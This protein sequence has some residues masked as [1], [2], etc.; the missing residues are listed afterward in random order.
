MKDDKLKK[1]STV[2]IESTQS[3]SK[4][5]I[6]EAKIDLPSI[7]NINNLLSAAEKNKGIIDISSKKSFDYQ[8]M[9]SLHLFSD[10]T[11]I[12]DLIK[13]KNY[14]II[15]Y[16]LG[17]KNFLIMD[18]EAKEDSSRY[19][20]VPPLSRE[21]Y[22]GMAYLPESDFLLATI[23]GDKIMR[24]WNIQAHT[25]HCE[26]K[27]NDLNSSLLQSTKRPIL[28]LNGRV[29]LLGSDASIQAWNI[30][31]K[32]CL[33]TLSDSGAAVSTLI[34][35]DDF[36][37]ISGSEDG[38]IKIW[39]IPQR[40]CSKVLKGH[41]S[42]ITCFAI[43][44][45]GK[46][47]SGSY[48]TVIR[49]W[50]SLTG[51]CLFK[52]EGHTG[53]ITGLVL[54][55]DGQLVSCSADA[56]IKIWDLSQN[57]C[58]K[59][60][61]DHRDRINAVAVDERNNLYSVSG[62]LNA[63]FS[64]GDTSFRIWNIPIKS[65][66]I[67]EVQG[68]LKQIEKNPLVTHL[69]L[70]NCVLGNESIL[71]LLRILQ[72]HPSMVSVSLKNCQIT[73][74]GIKI[75]LFGLKN[76]KSI[77]EINISNNNFNIISL[78]FMV[79]R[80]KKN[81]F[82]LNVIFQE[83]SG[84]P[85]H[86]LSSRE[87]KSSTDDFDEKFALKLQKEEFEKFYTL[88][89]DIKNQRYS[90]FT[91]SQEAPVLH[92]VLPDGQAIDFDEFESKGD[93]ACGFY[94]LGIKREECVEILLPLSEDKEVRRQLAKE[95][96][97]ELLAN[98]LGKAATS[99]AKN[100]LDRYMD[101]LDKQPALEKEINTEIKKIQKE[102]QTMGLVNLI[103]YMEENLTIYPTLKPSLIRLKKF[104]E[105]FNQLEVETEDYCAS[106]EMYVSYITHSLGKTGW[107][108]YQSALL[109]AREKNFD[110]HIWKKAE[111]ASTTLSYID[112][113]HCDKPLTT[114]HILHTNRFTHFNLLAET[115]RKFTESKEKKYDKNKDEKICPEDDKLEVKIS[116]KLERK[117]EDT[118]V[119][120]NLDLS[121]LLKNTSPVVDVST[122]FLF[123]YYNSDILT[124]KWTVFSL[125]LIPPDRIAVGPVGDDIQIWNIRN[126]KL[127]KTISTGSYG[128][129]PAWALAYF[130]ENRLVSLDRVRNARNIYI[131][132]INTGSLVKKITANHE[133]AIFSMLTWSSHHL[134]TAGQEG[135]VR[136][137]D[138]QK[139][140]LI[141]SLNRE[142]IIYCMAILSYRSFASG[143]SDGFIRIYNINDEFKMSLSRSFKAHEAKIYAIAGLKGYKLASASKDHTVKIWDI[144]G[145]T[146]L[147]TL[148]GHSRAVYSL[149]VL[150]NDKLASAGTDR[151][152]II[153]DTQ[154]GK[155][156]ATLKGHQNR[157]NALVAFNDG[158]IVSGSGSTF[159]PD[160]PSVRV[161]KQNPRPITNYDLTKLFR[162]LSKNKTK[163][164]LILDGLKL[165]H[166]ILLTL[167]ELVNQNLSLNF[168][169]LRNCGI[170]DTGAKGLFEST[171]MRKR[172]I[173]ISDNPIS[174][175]TMT[176]FM[177][178]N[179]FE[180]FGG[181][182]TE[183]LILDPSLP[184]VTRS[185]LHRVQVKV[186]EWKYFKWKEEDRWVGHVA[187]KTFG[188][189]GVYASFWPGNCAD[190]GFCEQKVSH[191]HSEQEDDRFFSNLG[192]KL[193]TKKDLYT[194]DVNTINNAFNT[195]KS[196]GWEWA[197]RGSGFLK[198]HKHRNCSGLAFHLLMHG[199]IGKL[200]A[201][202]P[203][204]K[205]GEKVGEAVRIAV[206]AAQVAI[207]AA[208]IGLTLTDPQS[209][210]ASNFLNVSRS[211]HTVHDLD[212]LAKDIC[213]LIGYGIDGLDNIIITPSD[214]SSIAKIAEEN[215]RKEHKHFRDYAS[216]EEEIDTW[217]KQPKENNFLL[218]CNKRI[219]F[220][221]FRFFDD[222]ERARMS[223]VCQ[224]YY[225]Y[226]S[227]YQS[228]M[229]LSFVS[230]SN[231]QLPSE[232]AGSTSSA[233]LSSIF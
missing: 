211:L 107:L 32:K 225:N 214:I 233:T 62:K 232:S 199:D 7:M 44:P 38:V 192:Q 65:P 91:F 70:D 33:Y 54:L 13:V 60:L 219:K 88:V 185:D 207:F 84:S 142:A 127:L 43:L 139:E 9:H 222:R 21:L 111:R 90:G 100:L 58:I 164:Q 169:S 77:Q 104:T 208:E 98:S 135:I 3:E 27:V 25:L 189:D 182:P 93:G 136:L 11:T 173:A 108:G 145:A 36:N 51:E 175:E 95:I 134:I 71:N 172:V 138:L 123:D 156:I 227:I 110:L 109:L 129:S 48:D 230:S 66:G 166:K 229:Q 86:R 144:Y 37:I 120:L 224:Y 130:P 75:L 141:S 10:S 23:T 101:L 102:F 132:N 116:D 128:G 158:T 19:S 148:I 223:L 154:K 103:K 177:K 72:P 87:L 195:F 160:E 94:V 41:T 1:D 161:W 226:S 83:E 114:Y 159:F 168:L 178:T 220:S 131:W 61:T 198:T 186:W 52:L 74:T 140:K 99:Q 143:S 165:D 187:V 180:I 45:N 218:D 188:P 35:R 213:K 200:I 194:L 149:A 22:T 67:A 55:S 122:A 176:S 17:Y 12:I 217:K 73:E 42:N 171:E 209:A 212:G 113:H 205:R 115:K 2:G 63:V 150:P 8:K 162:L 221:L 106:E 34:K 85:L 179:Q 133:A 119:P 228:L 125:A 167:V 20:C 59:T 157:I 126:R 215:E 231:S 50:N 46:I 137:W 26:I 153:W 29:V 49:I 97:N 204:R 89:D 118:E 216:R 105:E 57:L 79:D 112:G 40:K 155:Y 181:Q 16:F 28:G 190:P 53:K 146:C 4:L 174:D 64:G 31:Q 15:M 124:T 210:G 47:A 152:I 92:G 206:L 147:Y 191:F 151:Q 96:R 193:V 117:L 68:L 202:Y 56:T 203:F 82:N 81:N 121:Y 197:V 80:F 163:R 170:D 78:K 24:V 196:Y 39:N 18:L 183:S 69:N 201:S 5:S 184:R 30:E 6:E 14:L 76:N